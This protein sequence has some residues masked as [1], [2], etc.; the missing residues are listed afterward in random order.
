MVSTKVCVPSDYFA[1][2]A[3]RRLDTRYWVLR[4]GYSV[5]GPQL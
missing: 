3:G 5:L 4:T 2:L 1:R